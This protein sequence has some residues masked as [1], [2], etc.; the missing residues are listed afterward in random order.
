[1]CNKQQLEDNSVQNRRD[2]PHKQQ[3]NIDLIQTTTSPNNFCSSYQ[4]TLFKTIKSRAFKSGYDT[5]TDENK[6]TVTNLTIAKS[7]RELIESFSGSV[8]MEGIFYGMDI[9]AAGRVM[10]DINIHANEIIVVYE[11]TRQ[12]RYERINVDS[13]TLTDIAGETLAKDPEAFYEQWG[14]HFL[15]SEAKGDTFYFILTVQSE[16]IENLEEIE[17]ELNSFFDNISFE[18]GLGEAINKTM[19]SYNTRI[20]IEQT[21]G[22][23][24]SIDPDNIDGLLQWLNTEWIPA[25]DARPS[26]LRINFEAFWTLAETGDEL[27]NVVYNDMYRVNALLDVIVDFDEC[28]E[29]LGFILFDHNNSRFPRMPVNFYGTTDSEISTIKDYLKETSITRVV[30]SNELKSKRLN[31]LDLDG[32]FAQSNEV[33]KRPET[34]LKYI[35]DLNLLAR[36]PIVPGEDINLHASDKYVGIDSDK[37]YATTTSSDSANKLHLLHYNRF[38]LNNNTVYIRSLATEDAKGAQV[39]TKH[40][41]RNLHYEKKSATAGQEWK[42]KCSEVSSNDFIRPKQALHISNTQNEQYMVPGQ[43]YLDTDSQVCT[44]TIAR[45]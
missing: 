11:I 44:W 14:S 8:S 7:R 42:I 25:I 15:A 6:S 36:Y 12:S 17:V 31:H 41:N 3:T 40:I 35:R 34:Y 32:L 37:T 27:R 38:L 30:I 9:G 43:H 2:A 24:T 16:Q 26:T 23:T 18:S 20:Y 28:N 21:G 29:Q 4:S 13:L 22:P 5:K 1:M 39:L 10:Q 33:A 19:K 45:R